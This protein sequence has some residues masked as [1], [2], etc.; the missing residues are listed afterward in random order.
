MELSELF[1]NNYYPTGTKQRSVFLISVAE[2][3]ST[4]EAGSEL[5][6][7]FLLAAGVEASEKTDVTSTHYAAG[8][9]EKQQPQKK[10]Q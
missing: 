6:I 2:Q 1:Y 8:C 7:Y 9:L 5:L 3:N 10:Q 4:T